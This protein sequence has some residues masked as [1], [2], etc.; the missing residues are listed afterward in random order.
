[1]KPA[2]SRGELQA[3]MAGSLDPHVVQRFH[4]ISCRF[5]VDIVHFV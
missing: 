4:I 3:G 5:D 1:M 2:L